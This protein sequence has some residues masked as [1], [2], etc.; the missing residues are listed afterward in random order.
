MQLILF[1]FVK[2]VDGRC[3]FNVILILEGFYCG[4]VAFCCTIVRVLFFYLVFRGSF[5][6]YFITDTP[7]NYSHIVVCW[8]LGIFEKYFS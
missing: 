2:I 4:V 1:S 5:R 7:V 6:T 3:S 8:N